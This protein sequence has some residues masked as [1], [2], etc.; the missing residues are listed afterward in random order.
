MQSFIPKTPWSSHAPTEEKVKKG[1]EEGESL[2]T[3]LQHAED[4]SALTILIADCTEAMRQ[5]ILDSFD[6]KQTGKKSDTTANLKGDQALLDQELDPGTVNVA[7]KDREKKALERR[8]KELSGAAMQE[9]KAA[10]LKHFD[11]WRSAVIQ[12]VGEIVN[13]KETAQQHSQH[14]NPRARHGERSGSPMRYPQPP[15][16][17]PNVGEMMTKLYP[18][19]SNV[20]RKLPEEQRALI[21]H[22]VLLLLLSLEHYQSYSRTVLL[23]L[24]TSL[25]LS[26]SFLAQDESKIARG[27]LTAAANMKADEET[28]KRAEEN[29]SNRKWKVGLATVAGAALIGVTGG[30]A[31]PL[32]AAGVGSVMG[33]LGLGATA[34]AG[35]LGTLAGSTVLVGGLFGAYGGRMTGQMMDQYAR[36]VE[37]FGFVPVKTHHKPRKIESEYR[38]L[39]VAIGISGWL[40]DK[41]EVVEPW[42]VVG[43]GMETFALRWELEALMNLGNSL[44]TM[45]RSAAWGYAKSEI[46]KRTVF[47]SLMAGLWPLG[48][49]KVSRLIDN[50]WSV[51][52]YRAIKAGEVLADA[53]I[54]KAQGERPVTL[55]G[56]SLGAK[57]IFTCLQKLAERKAF[58]LVES[59][60]LIGTPAPST[61]AEWRRIRA[62]VS[63]RVVN[64]YST[65][66]Y[67]LAFLYRSSSIQLG[68]AGLQAVEDVKGIENVDVS[69]MVTGHTSYRFLTGTIL[70]KIGF[71]DVDTIELEKAEK[72]L[73]EAEAKEEKERKDSE[74]AEQAKTPPTAQMETTKLDEVHAA[75]KNAL[76]GT[77]DQAPEVT[78]QQ[79][80]EMEKEIDR[81]NQE[82]YIGWAQERMVGAGTNVVVAYE[83]AKTQWMLRKQGGVGKAAAGTVGAA[84][85]A[86]S[87]VTGEV[88]GRTGAQGPGAGD[89]AYQGMKTRSEARKA[90][91]GAG[92]PGI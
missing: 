51:A 40:T 90:E 37:D 79:V 12:R 32:L 36:E 49:L 13:S 27:L 71:E 1:D 73:R 31:A 9:L 52:H 28:K 84:D 67:I 80:K 46:I 86:T 91:G 5:N 87:G 34:A 77:T 7:D 60:V 55:I 83:K 74:Q 56:Y 3:I 42:K 6:P 14:A 41:D 47:A 15:K 75:V 92:L 10:A 18:P 50:P 2:T 62:V 8:E 22:S 26:V 82:S 57:L 35:Y 21:L 17:D 25:D 78:D 66:D 44:T 61:A 38:R 45:V 43:T 29:Q 20:L 68:I 72:E 88:G 39:R 89:V 33:G 4:R 59:V 64:V 69:E 65:D 81:K 23:Y 54:N 24:T 19:T 58:G 53:L 11:D 48:L 16:Y 70:K 63:G 76:P 30:L 85:A